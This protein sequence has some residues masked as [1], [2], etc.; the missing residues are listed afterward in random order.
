[1]T[2]ITS[3]HGHYRSA[4]AGSRVGI[5]VRRITALFAAAGRAVPLHR[6]NTWEFAG[7]TNVVDRDRARVALELRA[8]ST[9]REHN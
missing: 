4:T 8:L 3:G 6:E 5:A 2:A 9:Y 1:M 7:S